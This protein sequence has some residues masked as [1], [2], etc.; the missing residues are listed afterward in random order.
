MKKI[1]VLALLLGGSTAHAGSLANFGDLFKS[2]RIGYTVNQHGERSDLVY[3]A[4]QSF[5]TTAGVDIA[6]VNIG[7]EGARKR[8]ALSVGL[9][10][11]NLMP[12]LWSSDWGKAHVTTAKLPT[13]ECGPF[14]SAWPKSSADI[15]K[16]DVWYGVSLA[17][18]F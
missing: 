18:G 4:L 17:V 11:D 10:F 5:H 9:R 1:L 12:M 14:V 16:V 2:M 7:Y 8:P 13:V 6:A 3:T 15:W